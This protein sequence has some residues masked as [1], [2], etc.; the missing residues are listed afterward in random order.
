MGLI[1]AVFGIAFIIGPIIAGVMLHYFKWHS[2]FIINLPVAIVLILASMRF[3][4]ATKVGSSGVFDWKGILS[5]GLMLAAFT[6]GV[7]RIEAS[8]FLHSILSWKVMPFLILTLAMG[9]LTFLVE[10]SALNPV[11]KLNYFR[12]RQIVIAGIIAVSTGLVQSTF[13]FI[14]DFAVGEFGVSSSQASFMLVPLVFAT[15][16]GSPV[17]GRLIDRYGSKIVINLALALTFIGFAILSVFEVTKFIFYLSGVFVGLG[18]SVLSGSSLR[19]IML[20][21]T[22]AIDRAVTQGMLTIFIS[23][24]QLTGAALIGMILAR[25]TVSDG[26]VHMFL[27]LSVMLVAVFVLSLRLK[28][29]NE[30]QDMPSGIS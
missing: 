11:L 17:F 10:K 22:E 7:N 26:Y 12:N 15:A 20:N 6:Y 29:R 4:P 9:M 30:E 23:L 21:E 3:I 27:F 2:L 19:Y 16:L 28:K 18:L 24:G 1:G 14:P 25:Y 5:L 8:S 13:V